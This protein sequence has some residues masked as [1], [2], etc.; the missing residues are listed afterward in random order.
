ME[1][2]A[3]GLSI[4]VERV[5]RLVPQLL[6]CTREAMTWVID[7]R[8]TALASK[9]PDEPVR[10]ELELLLIRLLRAASR[11]SGSDRQ[12]ALT[13]E[14][15]KQLNRDRYASLEAQ[16][17][18]KWVLT[19]PRDLLVESVSA[20]A[21]I[22]DGYDAAHDTAHAAAARNL[23]Y[24]IGSLV[25]QADGD[26]AWEEQQILNR[27]RPV[28][29]APHGE[30]PDLPLADLIAELERL[31]G[32]RAVK[33]DVRELV[34]YVRLQQLRRTQ[35]LK[36]GDVSLHMVFVGNPGTGKTTVARLVARVYKALGVLNVG[37]LVETDRAGLVAGYVG[38]TALK[39][40]D[41][42]NKALGGVLFIDEA[43]ALAR[44]DDN[45]FGGEAIEALL[46]RMEDHR[47]ELVVIAAGYPDEMSRFL[48]A[49][50]GLAS[51]FSKRLDFDD[52]APA[53]LLQILKSM[54]AGEQYVLSPGA[55][56]AAAAAC[57]RAYAQRDDRFGN[58]RFVR[59]LFE[60]GITNLATRIATLPSPGRA[61]LMTIE[62]I[63]I[64]AADSPK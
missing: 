19:L 26:L 47:E 58:A 10:N 17:A 38:Q 57:Q 54:C 55:E 56:S 46:K 62:A 13:V 23:L 51:R 59:N 32:L 52:Y 22:Q 42:V 41:V 9:N 53:E 5:L 3:S 63:D 16:S 6:A 21:A 2:A 7:K 15:L 8:P 34:N 39:V 31:I 18:R 64:E 12:I 11:R 50:P 28:T 36:A 35:H 4:D 25:A 45:D 33:E 27:L 1:S 40:N 48:D 61:A 49:N 43:Y 60:A 24:Q 20:I 37:H 29:E 44:S 14:I 30:P